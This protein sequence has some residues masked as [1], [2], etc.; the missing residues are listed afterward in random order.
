MKSLLFV[1]FWF[2]VFNSAFAQEIEQHDFA[3][4]SS[5]DDFD[6]PQNYV[7]VSEEGLPRD[8]YLRLV[9]QMNVFRF[10]VLSE[11]KVRDLF[12]GLKRNSRARM[13]RPGGSCSHRRSYIQNLLK[14]MNIVSGKILL[15]CPA[16]NG[17][18]RLQDQVSGRH[19]T[20]VNFHDTNIVAVKTNS[21]NDFRVMDL[22]FEDTPVS[23]RDYLTEIEASQRIRPLKR[24]GNGSNRGRCYWSISTQHLTF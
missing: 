13:R 4:I 15:K 24:K 11:T 18:L 23:L 10:T 5:I 3:I 14:K 7:E 20:Y 19:Y 22:Q 6:L 17:R 12:E 16:N 21:G 9:Q 2:C 8:H 1:F